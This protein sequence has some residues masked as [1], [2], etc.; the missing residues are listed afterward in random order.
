ME[1]RMRESQAG[2]GAI[3]DFGSHTLDMAWW[4]L[5]DAVGPLVSLDARLATV[6]RREGRWPT[7][8][9][10]AVMTG[11]FASG[12]LFEALDSRVGPG[13]Y[14]IEVYGQR[15]RALIDMARP[16][17]LTVVTYGHDP[18]T[19]VADAAVVDPFHVQMIRFL[20]AVETGASADP[21]FHQGVAVQ[22]WIEAAR[23]GAR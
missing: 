1:W 16:D 11:R 10:L 14:Q 2:G 18:E 3:A 19:L 23:Q 4:L 13:L 7:N 9:D 20:D 6:M 5:A 22:R 17:T 21:D 12:A 8:D 15:G